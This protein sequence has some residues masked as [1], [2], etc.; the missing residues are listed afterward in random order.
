VAIYEEQVKL[1]FLLVLVITAYG[2]EVS[3]HSFLTSALEGS[4]WSISF[5]GSFTPGDHE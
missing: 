1:R 5:I 3:F 2:V 4:E